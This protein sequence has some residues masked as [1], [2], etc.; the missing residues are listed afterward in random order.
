VVEGRFR[1]PNAT[2]LDD[3][4]F[5]AAEQNDW[6]EGVNELLIRR[7]TGDFPLKEL[8]KGVLGG[9]LR[10][11]WDRKRALGRFD[12]SWSGMIALVVGTPLRC[13]LTV[14]RAVRRRRT[15]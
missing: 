9:V 12:R 13:A 15:R 14:L 11:A 8:E 2:W 6:V 3:N 5:H 4:Y 1:H 7:A 10:R